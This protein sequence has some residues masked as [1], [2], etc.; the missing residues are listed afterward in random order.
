M[1]MSDIESALEA[2]GLTTKEIKVYLVLLELGEAT[3]LRISEL[4]RIN[5]TTLYD[6]LEALVKKGVAGSTTKE[7][8]KYFYAAKPE[9]LID[10]LK[11]KQEAIKK[12]LPALVE[13]AGI[14]GKR[15]KIEFYEGHKGIDAIHQDVLGVAKNI[16]AYGSY[17]ITG[18]AAKYQSLDFRK[19]RIKLK[20]PIVAVTD[21]SATE[22]EM[23]KQTEYRR[24]TKI[25]I[26]PALQDMP[27][28]T[29]IY[30]NKVAIL[31]FEKEQFFGFVVESPS[32]VAKEQFLFDKL[33]KQA[34]PLQ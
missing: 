31:L 17:A 2:W 21:A 22:I 20:I 9:V 7:K 12:I 5:R 19:R 24:F 16:Y 18:K 1:Y 8:V 15:P 25:Y 27:T 13:R 29:Y 23:L 32:I 14:V 3:T 10:G 6:L 30:E 4:T 11:E 33:I 28:W 26:D 34:K